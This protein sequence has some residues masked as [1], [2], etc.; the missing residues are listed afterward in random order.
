MPK[1][2][3]NLWNL[4]RQRL[5]DIG[6]FFTRIENR[7]GGGIPDTYIV[8]D[9]RSFWVELKVSNANKVNV[10]PHQIAWHTSHSLNGGKSFFLVKHLPSSLLY[11]FEGANARD[12]SRFGL[13][14]GCMVQGSWNEIFGILDHKI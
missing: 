14:S 1:P 12:L 4:F 6:Y 10:S 2:E 11:L 3:T 7:S 13:K 5:K 8:G 9:G